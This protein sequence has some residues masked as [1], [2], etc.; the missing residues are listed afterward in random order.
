MRRTGFSCRGVRSMV[1]LVIL[2]TVLTLCAVAAVSAGPLEEELQRAASLERSQDVEGA[3]E[4]FMNIEDR[5]PGNAEALRGMSRTARKAGRTDDWIDRLRR[6]FYELRNDRNVAA[7]YLQSLYKSGRREECLDLG[8]ESLRRWPDSKELYRNLSTLYR[9]NGMVEEAIELLRQGRRSTGNPGLFSREMAE[10]MLSGGDYLPAV[11]EYL[12]FLESH[13]A[14]ISYV[15]RRCLEIG[16][17]LGSIERVTSFVRD[18]DKSARCTWLF[19]LLVDLQIADLEYEQAFTLIEDCSAGREQNELLGELIRLARMAERSGDERFSRRVL[20]NARA[21]T[22]ESTPDLRLELARE[23]A[24]RDMADESIE[25]LR[26]LLEEKTSKAIKL[27]CYELLGD[28]SLSSRHDPSAAL[29]WYRLMEEEGVPPDITTQLRLK[30]SRAL[31]ADGELEQA[32]DELLVLDTIPVPGNLRAPLAYEIGNVSFYLGRLDEAV[33]SYRKLSDAAHAYDMTNEAI[34]I[35]RLEKNYGDSDRESLETLGRAFY[36]RRIDDREAAVDTF[37]EAIRET[38][39]TALQGEIML[40]LA[41]IRE[42][43]GEVGEALALYEEVAGSATERYLAARALMGKALIEFDEL[44][45]RR[46]ARESLEK[47]VLDYSDTIEV[48]E[49]RHLLAKLKE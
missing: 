34:D 33:A 46:A 44:G 45:D 12:V 9:S 31:I 14:S 16:R 41:R 21:F 5:F 6:R 25:M 26:A 47:L 3:F 19:P 23:L 30:V 18:Y 4:L 32:L 27:A 29:A 49:A 38:D 11:E 36:L 39:N 42:E 37:L 15:E 2:C 28:L 20:E 10:L 8:R 13:P 43:W 17:A 1:G 7:S 22:A 48:E 35:L 24:V 40:M